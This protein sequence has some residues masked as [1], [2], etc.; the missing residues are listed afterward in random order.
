MKNIDLN[1]DMGEGMDNE[2]LIMPYISSCNIS[3]GAH[4]GSEKTIHSTIQE[5]Q[6]H[7]VKI[8]AHPSYPDQENF[9]RLVMDM[10]KEE[11]E[12]SI[13]LQLTLFK[14]ILD[15]YGLPLHH[16]KPHGALYNQAAVDVHIA[17]MI[18]TIMQKNFPDA[19]L[20]APDQSVIASLA[21]K[22][23]IKVWH[24]AFA[25]RN[26][27][28]DLTL[29]PR[30]HPLAVMHEKHEII[31]HISI[32]LEEQKVK[33]LSGNVLPLKVDTIC[34][35]GDNPTSPLIAEAVRERL[36]SYI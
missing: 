8:G 11:L 32:M 24:E 25:D 26:Y 36:N 31:N 9:G 23:N 12:E 4:A 35:H 21:A 29:I 3:C 6:K 28:D 1:C 5:A 14:S 13:L 7:G 27:A 16:I 2:H 33:A 30:I 15:Q 34:I 18:L 10:G 20:Y 19:I 17:E 22:Y